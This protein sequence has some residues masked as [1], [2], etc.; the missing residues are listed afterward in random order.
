[1]FSITIGG[2]PLRFLPAKSGVSG[3]GGGRPVNERKT[4][5]GEIVAT[6]SPLPESRRLIISAPEGYAITRADAEAIRALGTGPFDVTLTGYEPSGSFGGCVFEELPRFPPITAEL[7]GYDMT[8]YI[9][10]GA[11]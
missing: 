7:V 1:M 4:I 8:I 2:V 10:Q 3:S 11:S 6:R 9:P 5:T